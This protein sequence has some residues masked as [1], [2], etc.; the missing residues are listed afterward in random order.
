MPRYTEDQLKSAE[1]AVLEGMSIRQAGRDWGIPYATL[2]DRLKGAGT[3]NEAKEMYQ[4]LSP[5]DE[6]ALVGWI[7]VQG[8]LGW[9]PTHQQ[10]RNLASRIVVSSGDTRPLGRKWMEGF[11][12]RHPSIRS[13]KA[14]SID[15]KRVKEVNAETIKDLFKD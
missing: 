9:A 14:R 3:R 11:L 7:T 12:R 1:K 2:S 4:R 5:E 6:K 13:L 15:S 8:Q 10:V